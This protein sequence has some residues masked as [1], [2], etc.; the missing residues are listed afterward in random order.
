MDARRGRSIFSTPARSMIAQSQITTSSYTH[1]GPLC[2]CFSLTG[3]VV[4]EEEVEEP[5]ALA[6]RVHAV[7]PEEGAHV[8]VDFIHWI[9][10]WNEMRRSGCVENGV[11]GVVDAAHDQTKGGVPSTNH[12]HP[13][14]LPTYKD[15]HTHREMKDWK[16]T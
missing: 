11:S 2:L 13:T 6:D 1:I 16:S 14:S 9:G 4:L 10:D 5:E 8:S 12:H 3:V 15:G 7:V